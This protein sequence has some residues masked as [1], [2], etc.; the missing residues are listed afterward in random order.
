[1]SSFLKTRCF[2]DSIQAE[3]SPITIWSLTRGDKSAYMLASSELEETCRLVSVGKDVQTVLLLNVLICCSSCWLLP[4]SCGP[5]ASSLAIVTFTAGKAV[6]TLGDSDRELSFSSDTV[7]DLS[8]LSLIRVNN[9]F[10]SLS[11]THS[12]IISQFDFGIYQTSGVFYG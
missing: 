3:F 7:L 8:A 12:N 5:A 1:M 4:T 6:T 10:W 9:G 2:I 11:L